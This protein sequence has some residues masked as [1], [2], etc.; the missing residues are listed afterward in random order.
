MVPQEACPHYPAAVYSSVFLLGTDQLITL[1]AQTQPYFF[2]KT[3]LD[4][5]LTRMGKVIR[6]N[7]HPSGDTYSFVVKGFL[8]PWIKCN[9]VPGS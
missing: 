6:D 7:H 3:L 1:H 2:G 5:S 9:P 4:L 8:L